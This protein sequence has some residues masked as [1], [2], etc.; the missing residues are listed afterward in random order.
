M[1][2]LISNISTLSATSNNSGHHINYLSLL[3][4]HNVMVYS[5]SEIFGIG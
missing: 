5:A 2:T 3:L 1:L 4:L